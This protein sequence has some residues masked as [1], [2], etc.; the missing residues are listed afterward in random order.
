[1]VM[2]VALVPHRLFMHV[3]SDTQ[4][5][6]ARAMLHATRDDLL[7]RR[8]PCGESSNLIKSAMDVKP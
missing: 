3:A 7:E 4:H 8:K 5:A 6:F 2:S 1:M